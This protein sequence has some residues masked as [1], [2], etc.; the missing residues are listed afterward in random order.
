MKY[1][2][3]DK[4]RIVANTSLHK[5]EIGHESEIT[6]LCNENT[7][8]E[9]YEVGGEKGWFCWESE[10]ELVMEGGQS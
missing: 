8:Y 1:K 9:H 7:Q 4:V 6:K 2:V 5:F 3:G 10:L